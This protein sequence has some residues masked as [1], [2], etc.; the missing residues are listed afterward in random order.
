MS[1][2]SRIKA[3]IVD[4]EPLAREKIRDMLKDDPSIEVV[5]ECA[6]GAKA[7]SA[8]EKLHPDLL[9]L[10]IQMPQMDGFAVLKTIP[11]EN[12]PHVIFVTAHDQ[13][14]LKAFEVYALDYLLKP[15]DKE[16][17]RT[18]LKRAKSQVRRDQSS[19]VSSGIL[20]L[21]EE[22]QESNRHLDRLVIK[23]SGRI[24]FIK[25]IDI[26]WIEADGNYVRIHAGKESHLLREPISSL[27]TQLNAKKFLRIHRSTIV[28]LDRIHE[29]QPWFHGEYRIILKDG[30]QLMLS[31]SYRDRLQQVLGKSV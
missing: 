26:D 27:E 24:H 31:R 28:N 30:T 21:L 3:I 12:L 13:Y 4:D 25:T 14:A 29:L 23:N 10:D 18:A 8:I 2:P 22:L 16:R 1:A 9:F 5:A 20:A 7:V 15:F 6:S 19:Q 17:F 11:Q